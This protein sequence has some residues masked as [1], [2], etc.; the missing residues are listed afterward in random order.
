MWVAQVHKV[1]PQL[2]GEVAEEV[3]EVLLLTRDPITDLVVAIAK[4]H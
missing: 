3:V 2:R 4:L 1:L